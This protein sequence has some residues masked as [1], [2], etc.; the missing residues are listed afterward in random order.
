MV[1]GDIARSEG[2][3]QLARELNLSRESLYRSFSL[4]TGPRRSLLRLHKNVEIPLD[5]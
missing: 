5:K 1:I 3:T 4:Q 2:M